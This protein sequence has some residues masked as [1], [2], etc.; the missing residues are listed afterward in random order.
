MGVV[1][2]KF[3]VFYADRK[4]KMAATA[5]HRLTNVI[6]LITLGQY[7]LFYIIQRIQVT[8][9]CFQSLLVKIL[10]YY[11]E[12]CNIVTFLFLF[13][14]KIVNMSCDL[15]CLLFCQ[16]I[17]YKKRKTVDEAEYTNYCQLSFK[18]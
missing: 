14:I 18:V 10:T 16:F 9:I 15:R 12:L 13:N 7:T 8:C 6:N 3:Y 4:S 1:F 2:P 11:L 5:I 17:G